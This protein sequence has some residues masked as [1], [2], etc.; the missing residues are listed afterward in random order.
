MWASSKVSSAKQQQ[1]KLKSS[2]EAVSNQSGQTK[3]MG[4][5]IVNHEKDVKMTKDYSLN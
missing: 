2:A 4:R 3:V 5:K 1:Q